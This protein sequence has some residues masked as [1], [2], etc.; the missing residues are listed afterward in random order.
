MKT[1]I[2]TELH[3]IKLWLE[4]IEPNALSQARNLANLPFAFHHI[5]IMPDAHSGYGMPIGSV[6]ATKGVIIPNAVGV[7]IGCGMCALKTNVDDLDSE[8]LKAILSSIRKTIPVGRNWHSEQQDLSLMPKFQ[9]HPEIITR[10][11]KNASF[12]LGTLGGGNHFIE[13]QRGSDGF[14]WVMIH[15]GSRNLGKTVAEHYNT[16]AKKLNERWHTNV[17]AQWDL[18]FLP[19]ET[20]EAHAYT[21]EM[22]YCIEF[23]LANRKLM[24]QRIQ[25]AFIDV[26][27]GRVEFGEMINKTHNFAAWEHHYNINVLVH[28]KGATRARKGEWGIIPGSQGSNPSCSFPSKIH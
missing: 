18:A 22:N 4:D 5:S 13:I 7:D 25:H 3:P 21:A 28:R 8:N 27:K 17:P 24:M 6:L 1:I 11:F 16:I 23:A 20:D 15:S 26:L 10:Q 2:S 9:K 14:I 19:I 12:Q